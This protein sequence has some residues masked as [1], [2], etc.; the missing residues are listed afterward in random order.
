MTTERDVC[1]AQILDE[2]DAADRGV[3]AALLDDPQAEIIDGWEDQVASAERLL[4][5]LDPDVL[6]GSKRWAYYPWRRALI[7]VLAREP[8]QA[9]R[10]DRNR[11]L[12]TTE[13]QR[14]IA[15][16]R[17]GVVGLSVGHAVAHMLAAEGLCGLL[18]LAD[19]DALEVSNLNRVPAT[20]FD[21][22]LNKA[23]VAARRI[24]E[25]DPYLPVEVVTSGLSDDGMDAFLEGLDVVVE[26]CDSLDMKARVREAAR[27]RRIPV[28]MA[29]AD[30][31]LMDVERFDLEPTR[32]IL[33]GLLGDLDINQL[34]GLSSREKI[35]Y[36]L[37]IL[38]AVGLS[39][40]SAASLV[41]IDQTLGTWPQL[42]GEVALGA[43][44]VAEAVRRI[45]LGEPLGS[46]RTRIDVAQALD[47]LIEPAAHF[48]GCPSGEVGC[49][50]IWPSD[51][52]I[53]PDIVAA[54]ANRAPSVANIQ[55]WR[56]ESDRHSVTI[57]LT[58]ERTAT[59]DIDF[60]ASAAAVGSALFNARVAA[61]KHGMLGPVELTEGASSLSA[62]VRLTEGRD[63][64][65]ARLYEAMRARE[66][67]RHLGEPILITDDVAA[68]LEAAAA[69]EGA[70]LELLT[71]QGDIEDISRIFAATD[72]IRYLTP[73]MHAEMLSEIRW[74]ADGSL[75]SGIDIR[76]LEMDRSELAG[77]QIARR[78]DVITKLAEWGTGIALGDYTRDR[79]RASSG[80]G[81]VSIQ[82]DTLADYARGGAAMEAVWITAQHLGLAVMP[83]APVFLYAR[84]DS[85]VEQLSPSY[86]EPLRRL[87]KA[88]RELTRTRADEGHIV[89]LRFAHAP[90]TSVR[91][92]RH[93][94][95]ALVPS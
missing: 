19:F 24:A 65:L 13:E 94:L 32:P 93:R 60:R 62:V 6:A 27:A 95:D 16:L 15:R 22:G 77:F 89:M 45:G 26:E 2:D 28:L 7:S 12:I 49:E 11:N 80:L 67:N 53:L 87:Q 57:R 29:T 66:T 61:A 51:A 79:I 9:L 85:E 68:A 75:E 82:G 69:V 86:A 73:H 59:L 37:R 46:G 50:P 91:S 43:A 47:H 72:R 58:T 63:P 25:L 8:F 54:A 83:V 36:V 71:D 74:P 84:D 40:R 76:S 78:T 14:Q 39:A 33:H 5:P 34:S 48:D 42:A 64:N 3:L 10:L 38:D 70:R 30:R 81:I 1:A 20:V 90:A 55:P 35:P 31:G 17:I 21:L 44:A 4:P 92:L 88:F 52:S 56:I 41:E 18:R 23:V